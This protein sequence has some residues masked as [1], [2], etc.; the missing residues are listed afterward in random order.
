MHPEMA[1]NRD[2]VERFLREGY[3]A[4]KV[5]HPGAVSIIDDGKTEDGAAFLVMELLEGNTLKDLCVRSKSCLT[6]PGS[7]MARIDRRSHRCRLSPP[8]AACGDAF[9]VG[10]LLTR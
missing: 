3:V 5:A 9:G 6:K 4:N 10:T 1:A 7:A 8:L 2:L